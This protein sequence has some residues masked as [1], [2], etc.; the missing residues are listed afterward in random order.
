[1]SVVISLLGYDAKTVGAWKELSVPAYVYGAGIDMSLQPY[2]NI[3]TI[4]L[5]PQEVG[6]KVPWRHSRH[7]KDTPS[8]LWR[9][10]SKKMLNK[11]G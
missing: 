8:L 9:Q 11:A 1:M 6:F 5:D 7:L 3:T 4:M 10:S 2:G